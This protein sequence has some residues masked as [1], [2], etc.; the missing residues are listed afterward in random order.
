VAGGEAGLGGELRLTM[1]GFL[2]RTALVDDLAAF[3][4]AR[5]NVHL[6]LVATEARRDLVADSFDLAIR[7]GRLEDSALQVRREAT[8]RRVLVAAPGWVAG[9]A[10]PVEADDLRGWDL[11]Q[12]D[13][14]PAQVVVRRRGT[15]GDWARVP[16]RA[17]ATCA[18][19]E[20]VLGLALRGLG[21]ATLPRVFEPE[22]LDDG[23]LVE[24]LPGWE[25]EALGIYLVWPAGAR[26]RVL[27]AQLAEFLSPCL[28]RIFSEGE[29]GEG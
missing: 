28:R 6:R 26:R 9:R 22:A 2:E 8:L 16:L 15:A 27:T 17:R 21:M 19:A 12:L 13:G 4:R 29:A 24:V 10:A 23:R 3:L 1:P 25:L 18:S 20:G 11:V 5:P 14:R 7:M